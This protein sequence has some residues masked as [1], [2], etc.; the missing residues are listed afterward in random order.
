MAESFVKIKIKGDDSDF[1]KKLEGVGGIAKKSFAALGAA[2]AAGTAVAVKAIADLAE[3]TREYRND[4]ATLTTSFETAG[5]TG[6]QAKEVFKDFYSFLGE[7]DRSVEASNHLAKF[8]DTQKELTQWTDIATGVWSQY[9]DSLPI[10]G[11]TEAANETIKTGKVTGVMADALNWAKAS[12]EEWGNALSVNANAQTAFNKA[13][14]AGMTVEDAFN[15][16]LAACSDEQE[17]QQVLAAG[18]AAVY[19]DAAEAYKNT[20]S[21]ILDA[22]R[23]QAEQQELLAKIGEKSEPILTALKVGWNE[24]LAALLELTEG[25]DFDKL[26]K[27][28][29]NAFGN[30]AENTLPKVINGVET[31]VKIIGTVFSVIDAALPAIV[32]LGTALVGLKLLEMANNLTI[33]VTSVK[34]LQIVTKAMAAVQWA[35]NAAMSANPI[36]LIIV[37]IT[38]LVAGLVVLYKKSETFRDFVNDL[39]AKLVDWATNTWEKIKEIWT[40]IEPYITAAWEVIKTIFLTAI[41]IIVGYFKTAWAV[42]QAVWDVVEPYF[43]TLVNIIS[44]AVGWLKD[45]MIDFFTKAWEA[46]KL[47]WDVVAP[48]FEFLWSTIKA[49]FSVVAAVLGGN[50]G[51][52]WKAI[53]KWWGSAVGYFR[54]IW[55]GIVAIFSGIVESFREWFGNAYNTVTEFFTIENFKKV[56]KES[57]VG[58][59][60]DIISDVAAAAKKVWE[61]IKKWLS[62]KIGITLGFG[63]AEGDGDGLASFGQ[64]GGLSPFGYPVSSPYNKKRG[65]RRHKG[66]DIA[67]PSGT[68]IQSTVMG[69]ASVR[70]ESGGFGKYVVVRDIL[71]NLH[72]F[73][74]MSSTAVRSGQMVIRGTRLGYVGSTGRS[75]GPHLHYGVKVGGSWVNPAQWFKAARGYATGGFPAKGEIFFGNEDGIEMM[76]RMGKQNVVA[77]NMQIIDGIRAGVYSGLLK[78]QRGSGN[79]TNNNNISLTQNFY[80]E[81]VS[82]SDTKRAARR[83]VREALAGGVT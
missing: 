26:G 61:E 54:G 41:D 74:H 57:I 67:A 4:I 9:Q 10:E 83:G 81:N 1:R 76:G 29:A 25:I 69:I 82:P 73:G 78:L 11:L 16:A 28:I 75:T 62:E 68:P 43:T 64:S 58:G 19:G 18:L 13:I 23:A 46:I 59:L 20:A 24:V 33:V 47:V 37:A 48:Y 53:E 70:H 42:I 49:I 51:D 52:A 34:N 71:G 12:S 44:V 77:N 38:A 31:F 79:R 30:F 5:F 3:E 39:F 60:E 15:E 21:S 65:N 56:F 35:L 80:K 8:C 55:D 45:N 63:G 22:N 40:E 66:I 14:E 72:Y 6:A 27:D 36:G 7:D 17:R 32:T 2:A 50:F